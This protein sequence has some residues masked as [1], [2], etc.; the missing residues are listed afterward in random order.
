MWQRRWEAEI[1]CHWTTNFFPKSQVT[2]KQRIRLLEAET[3]A[4][5]CG[6]KAAA[7]FQDGYISVAKSFAWGQSQFL[8]S[9]IREISCVQ[10][11][12]NNPSFGTWQRLQTWCLMSLST[13]VS[14]HRAWKISRPGIYYP[15]GGV[16]ERPTLPPSHV[17][18]SHPF[19]LGFSC[20]ACGVHAHKDATGATWWL[21]GMQFKLLRVL[22]CCEICAKSWL[23]SFLE[24]EGRGSFSVI[25]YIG[26]ASE[27]CCLAPDIF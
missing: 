3:H 17:A 16:A 26:L 23:L 20:V 24:A 21:Q 22:C 10:A 1:I 18:R 5:F 15:G 9:M 8:P 6:S 2:K 7:A 12:G 27:H 25:N 13:G 19:L 4:Y 14:M 11:G